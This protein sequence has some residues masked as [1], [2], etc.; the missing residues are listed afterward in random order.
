MRPSS[1][2]ETEVLNIGLGDVWVGSCARACRWLNRESCEACVAVVAVHQG[3]D[4]R[5]S[6][7]VTRSGHD[8]ALMDQEQGML[9]PAFACRFVPAVTCHSGPGGGTLKW[10][11]RMGDGNPSRWGEW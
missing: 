5:E 6:V 7:P 10:E 9:S 2:I 3:W 11:H 8:C 4:A 1:R